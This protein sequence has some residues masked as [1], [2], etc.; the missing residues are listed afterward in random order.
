MSTTDAL[1]SIGD[2]ADA[3]GISS[4]TL[5]IWERRY[6]RPEPVRL[7]SGHRRFTQEDVRWLRRVAEAMSRGFRP[8]RLLRMEDEELDALLGPTRG[9]GDTDAATRELIAL[10]R[11]YRGAEIIE[12]LRKVWQPDRHLAFL[13]DHLAPLISAVGAAWADGDMHVRHEHFVSEVV[14]DL[15][16]TLRQSYEPSEASP[17]LV[18]TTL[19]G[20]THGLGLQMCV[21]I[22]AA[23]GLPFRN[24]GV[25][26]PSEEIVRSVAEIKPRA[27]AISVS[28]ATGGV[29]TDRAIAA[30]RKEL[31]DEVVLYVGG[32]GARG[33]RRGPR[34]VNYVQDL[35]GW[36]DVVQKLLP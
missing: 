32:D 2:V 20:E 26:T 27:L 12:H 25:D 5:R 23:H 15:V 16:R 33:V 8:G 24:L 35:S 21:L 17:R 4:E 3:T 19:A 6:G 10:A 7:P 29:E 13:T 22:C 34:G 1:Y 30:L 11:E 9:A 18:L 31:P 36:D 28:L 14:Q